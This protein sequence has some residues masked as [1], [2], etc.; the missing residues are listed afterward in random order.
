MA[1]LAS[2]GNDRPTRLELRFYRVV[3]AVTGPAT[4]RADRIREALKRAISY[5]GRPSGMRV[6]YAD[7]LLPPGSVVLL[8]DEADRI[9]GIACAYLTGDPELEQACDEVLALLGGT[10]K[11]NG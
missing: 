2:S 8:P 1:R 7:D 9:E 6:D 4:A 5:A 3:V 10:D 11:D